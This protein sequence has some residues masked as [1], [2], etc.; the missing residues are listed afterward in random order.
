MLNVKLLVG[1]SAIA[2][3]AWKVW[4]SPGPWSL[5]LHVVCALVVAWAV[6]I[7][8][9][10]LT[11]AHLRRGPTQSHIPRPMTPAARMTRDYAAQ[12]KR[13]RR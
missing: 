11:A 7:V 1:S 8:A 2:A 9:L 4:S 10:Y 6:F 3:G 5:V 13:Q 12:F